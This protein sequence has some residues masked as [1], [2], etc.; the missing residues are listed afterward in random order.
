MRLVDVQYIVLLSLLFLL[1]C[2]GT[3]AFL[4]P[5][6]ARQICPS[7]RCLPVTPTMTSHELRS[8]RS[9]SQSHDGTDSHFLLQEFSVASG[10]II[11]P[12][13]ILKVSRTATREEIRASYI[14][15][16]RRYHPDGYRNGKGNNNILP[17]SCN[18]LDDVRDQWERIKL[19]YEILSNPKTRK[20]YDRHDVLSDPNAAM[21]RAMMNAAFDGITNVGKGLFGIGSFAVQAI[22]KGS[23]KNT[24]KVD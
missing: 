5:C 22:T 15:Q 13:D 8:A 17:G 23:D 11:N 18:N 21:K 9:S 24:Q 12:Y 3:A 16:S 10:E 4:I 6:D 1:T 19:S 20:R 7:W 14:K 2:K